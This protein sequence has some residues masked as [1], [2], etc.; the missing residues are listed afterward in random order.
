[1]LDTEIKSDKHVQFKRILK[2]FFDE[3]KDTLLAEPYL[4]SIQRDKAAKNFFGKNNSIKQHL[5]ALDGY[6]Y[7][8]SKLDDAFLR[9]K[10]QDPNVGENRIISNL[11]LRMSQKV[12]EK[13]SKISEKHKQ[14]EIDNILFVRK[15]LDSTSSSLH[16]LRHV[17]AC[18]YT[19][20][21]CHDSLTV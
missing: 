12:K 10:T 21:K 2:V 3:K 11:L 17:L 4:G 18:T 20:P 14:Q 1:M 16:K 19:C 8:L 13:K 7:I 9:Y 6:N 5:D 15:N